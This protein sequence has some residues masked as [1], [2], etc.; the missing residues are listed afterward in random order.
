MMYATHT[1]HKLTTMLLTTV[2]LLNHKH[3]NEVGA[4]KDV[5]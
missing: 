2:T 5:G 4:K 3:V 1:Q